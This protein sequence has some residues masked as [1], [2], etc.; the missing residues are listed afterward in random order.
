MQ[1]REASFT[2]GIIGLGLIG[3]SMARAYRAA[4]HKVY[5]RDR[6]ADVCR[7]ALDCGAADGLFDA[8][9]D[10]GGHFDCIFLAL[11]PAAAV[12]TLTELAHRLRGDTLVIDTCGVKR[13]VCDACHAIAAAHGFTFLGGHPMAGSHFSGFGAGRADLFR[14]ASMIVVP[15]SAMPQAE[16]EAAI[17]RARG[18]LAPLDFGTLTVC[19]AEHHDAMI[20]YTSQLAHVVSNAY[21]K[22]PTAQAHKG[23]S[24]G[25]Y[26]DLT[27]V[28]YLNAPMWTEL[29]LANRDNLV[30]ELDGII[31]ALGEYRDAMAAEDA[32]R[33]CTLLEEGKRCKETAQ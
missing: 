19:T 13:T 27:R 11:Y 14:D 1:E 7:L 12:E 6:S 5:V 16:A 33:L 3:G 2:I 28:A 29:F 31:A 4:G 32:E 26:K 24:A 17:E 30:R 25:S 18:L 21:V 9:L 23:Y 22:S 8:H 15:P 20:A 10:A